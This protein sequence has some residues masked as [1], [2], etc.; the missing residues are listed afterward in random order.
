[1]LNSGQKTGERHGKERHLIR[2]TGQVFCRHR[3]VLKHQ[4]FLARIKEAT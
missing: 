3:T 1:M 4:V 2:F